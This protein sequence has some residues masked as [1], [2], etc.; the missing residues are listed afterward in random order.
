M[1]EMA[2]VGFPT[3]L[4]LRTVFNLPNTNST[5]VFII[6]D[7]DEKM[8]GSALTLPIYWRELEDDIKEEMVQPPVFTFE[9]PSMDQLDW[10]MYS[11]MLNI[12]VKRSL[13][14]YLERMRALVEIQRELSGGRH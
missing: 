12:W 4:C 14:A 1:S 10:W 2:P 7:L 9:P 5:I 3:I 8:T 13:A 6:M 11:W